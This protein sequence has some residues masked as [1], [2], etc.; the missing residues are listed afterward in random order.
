MYLSGDYVL[1]VTDVIHDAKT[2]LLSAV[3][4]AQQNAWTLIPAA[5]PSELVLNALCNII[6][7][8]NLVLTCAVP[9]LK[10]SD[11]TGLR[12]QLLHIKMCS[13]MRLPV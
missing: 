9:L 8:P 5:C 6:L 11:S 2:N 10:Y 7:V 12:P 4:Q 1:V 13:R 3:A